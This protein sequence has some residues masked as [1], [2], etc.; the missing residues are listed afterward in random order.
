VNSIARRV[1]ACVMD[2]SLIVYV[3]GQ[4]ATILSRP[5]AL[6]LA[7]NHL[8]DK[9]ADGLAVIF[10]A[11]TI[12]LASIA[13]DPHRRF[14][15]RHFDERAVVNG[16]PFFLYAASLAV[17]VAAGSAITFG[18]GWGLTGSVAIGSA[19]MAYFIAEK[20]ADEVLRFRL[21]DSDLRAWGSAGIVRAVLQVSAILLLVRLA[22]ASI[23]AWQVAA[24]LALATAMVFLPQVP[25]ALWQVAARRSVPLLTWLTK[26]ALRWLRG[27][28]N[29]WVLALM[30]SGIAYLDRGVAAMLDRSMFPLFMLAAM[31]LSVIQTIVATLYVNRHRRALFDQRLSVRDIVTSADFIGV[32]GGSLLIGLV[33]CELMLRNSHN[34]SLFPRY[35][36]L[37]IAAI[38]VSLAVA[39]VFREIL[40]WRGAVRQMLRIEGLLYGTVGLTMGIAWSAGVDAKGV[41]TMVAACVVA[42]LA[43]YAAWSRPAARVQGT[44]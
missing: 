21:F 36:I 44:F 35:Y 40:Y 42:R 8:S 28:W 38:Q 18:V 6:F 14:Y 11:N 4:A 20:L 10:L 5:L 43:L 39:M 15:K 34:G 31:C 9:A 24:L 12:G 16:L 26:R 33:A 25:R 30:T 19:G 17:M 1:T 13:A 37:T 7:N 22:P 27:N 32:V 2:V 41:L 23:A 3:A 29:F